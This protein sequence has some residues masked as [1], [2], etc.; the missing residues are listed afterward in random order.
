VHVQDASSG[1][2]ALEKCFPLIQALRALE[3]ECNSGPLPPPYNGLEHPLHLNVGVLKSGDWPSTVPA[4]AE[5]HCRMAYLPGQS[6]EE[7]RARIEQ[8][9]ARAANED[10]W[11]AANPPEVDFYGFRS[12]GHTESRQAPPLAALN[13]CHRDLTGQDAPEYIS[14]CTTDLRAFYSHGAARG[15]CYGPVAE[16][17]HGADERVN[18]ESVLHT[19][20]AYALFAA[21]WCGLVE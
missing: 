15:C 7:L 13:Q 8:T 6:F 17:I 19:A 4:S 2:N 9:V 5:F 11:L 1:A 20:R 3:Q 10:A 12:D 18:L 14:T 21:R 16:R